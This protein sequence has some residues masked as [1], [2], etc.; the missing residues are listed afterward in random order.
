MVFEL[1]SD[2]KLL[3]DIQA[4]RK[5]DEP[6]LRETLRPRPGFTCHRNWNEFKIIDET[7]DCEELRDVLRNP[8]DFINKGHMIKEDVATTVA[9]IHSG[10]KSYFIKR[11]NPKSKLYGFFRSAIPSR[12]AVTWHA[13]QLLESVGVPTARPI[14]MLEKRFGPVKWESYVVHEYYESVHALAFFGEGAKP[15]ADWQPAAD[16]IIDILYILKRSLIIHG[17]LKGPNFIM[18]K[19][20]PLLIDLDSL[21]SYRLLSRFNRR[22]SKD[23]NRFERN[24]L[25]EPDARPSLSAND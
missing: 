8:D 14:A 23:L 19:K 6:S 17:D 21:K 13:A 22:Y 10:K 9:L 16:A 2:S 5:K 3:E 7:E 25:E 18:Y 1:T 12:A 15:T 24:W 4:I 11:Y 20:R